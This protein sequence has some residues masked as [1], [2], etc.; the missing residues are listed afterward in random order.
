MF[1]IKMSKR[2]SS[3]FYQTTFDIFVFSSLFFRLFKQT[4][5]LRTFVPNSKTLLDENQQNRFNNKQIIEMALFQI[6][7]EY[8]KTRKKQI[9]ILQF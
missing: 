3:V 6:K 7:Y 2:K 1:A 5:Q 9:G 8:S 4:I